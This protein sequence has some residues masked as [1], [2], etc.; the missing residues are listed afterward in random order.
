MN[1]G[2]NMSAFPTTGAPPTLAGS[3][4][5]R[6]RMAILSLTLLVLASGCALPHPHLP[7]AKPTI[8]PLQ[9][10]SLVFDA[11]GHLIT[12]LHAGENRTL[13]PIEDVPFVTRQAVVAAEDERFYQHHGV[14]AKAVIR[15]ALANAAQ[16]HVVQGA[17]T[18]TEQLVKNTI[19]TD[20][21]TLLRKIH[22]AETAWALED[23]YSKD[24]ILALYLNTVYFGQGAYGIQAAAKTY[25]SVPAKELDLQQSALLA[26]LIRSPSAYDPVF[27]PAL[28][29]E[30]RNYVLS[31]MRELGM[32]DQV[33][34]RDTLIEEI[35]LHPYQDTGRYPAAY[36]VDYVKRWFLSNEEFGSTYEDRYHLLFEGGLRISTTVDLKLQREAEKAVNSILIYKTDPY[37]AMTV[38]DPTTGAIKA[39]VGGRDFFSKKDRFAKLNLA[40]GGATGRSAGSSFKPFALVTALNKG[41]PPT[42][43][44]QAPGHI[45]IRLPHGYVPNI[46][47]VDNYDGTGSGSMTLED[48]TINSVNTVYA[49]LIMQVGPQAVVDVAHQMGIS[50]HLSAVPSAVLG[51]NE[52]DTL[53]MASAY[54]TLATMGEHADPMAVTKITDATGAVVYEADPQPEQVINPGVAWTVDQILQKV[55]QY[56]TGSQANIG[57]PVAGKTGT[58]QQWSDAWFV[59]FTPQLVAAVWVGFPQGRV[60]M[61]APRTRL[62]KVLGGRWPA[63]I[64]HAFMV[65]ATRDMRVMNFKRPSF[66]YVSVPVDVTRGCLP[67]SW[68]LPEDIQVIQYFDGTQP[69]YRC[70]EPSGPQMI[71]V[72]SV[73]GMSEEAA[74]ALL[75][76]Y[77]FTVYVTVDDAPGAQGVVLSQD[78][79]AGTQALQTTIVTI[80]VASGTPPPSPS[81]SPAPT[82]STPPP[83]PTPTPSPSPTPSP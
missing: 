20:E 24:E 1:Q 48:A 6:L 8:P 72:P 71:A 69:A 10:N 45:D 77:V 28:A 83:S 76:S 18:I 63:E 57:R 5:A 39:M 33:R 58:A 14:D 65:N 64:W 44:Y 53:Q 29:R 15:A 62:D 3:P 70:N 43:I 50:R 11:N 80:H 25:F 46:W 19:G 74:V 16:G 41:I 61:I 52:V 31:R 51:T 12:V 82:E 56:G 32:I 27:H 67:N 37:G 17:S 79:A 36:F 26:G 23:A 55:V 66:R 49:Q 40:T 34:Y 2:K 75:K 35:G 73:I 22:E 9:Q 21:R 13:I 47:P 54:G 59:G 30:R 7:E 38:M 60:R 42:Q 78:P 68:T 4:R 81:P